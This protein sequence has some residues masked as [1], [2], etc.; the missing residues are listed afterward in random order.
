[1]TP[2]TMLMAAALGKGRTARTPARR[3]APRSTG[4]VT[5]A[6]P[7]FARRG[8][9]TAYAAAGMSRDEIVRRTRLPY[10]A[11]ALLVPEVVRRTG[12]RA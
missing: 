11:V 6:L 1:M 8:A 10:D 4:S 3:S 2:V 9:I 12:G 5:S 7:P